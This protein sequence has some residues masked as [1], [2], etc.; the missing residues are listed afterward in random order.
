[1]ET[2]PAFGG[3]R[4]KIWCCVAN[5]HFVFASSLSRRAVI[6]DSEAR[7]NPHMGLPTF[8]LCDQVAEFV[9]IDISA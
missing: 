5:F 2:D 4:L 1:M 3:F 9:E 8:L 7:V 6:S